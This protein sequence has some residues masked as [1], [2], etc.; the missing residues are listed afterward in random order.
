MFQ[1]FRIVVAPYWRIK[2][3][4]V[5]QFYELKVCYKRF[6]KKSFHSKNEHSEK[7]QLIDSLIVMLRAIRERI[8]F[9]FSQGQFLPSYEV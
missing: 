3:I 5:D 6:F 1:S 4:W 8:G 2:L 9:Y 7:I